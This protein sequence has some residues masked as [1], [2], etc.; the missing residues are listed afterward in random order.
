MKRNLTRPERR[1]SIWNKHPPS[2]LPSDLHRLYSRT[3][4]PFRGQIR[5]D[6]GSEHKLRIEDL[7]TC[8]QCIKIRIYVPKDCR[9]NLELLEQQTRHLF[10]KEILKELCRGCPLETSEE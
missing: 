2:F 5:M 9:L 8:S 10:G 3:A 4:Y 7:T 1:E 6:S